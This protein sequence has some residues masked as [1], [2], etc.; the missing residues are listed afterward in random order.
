MDAESIGKLLGSVIS[1]GPV[2]S[3]S[4]AIAEGL[5]LANTL[6]EPNPHK[7]AKA[8]REYYMSMISLVNEVENVK[9]EDLETL[10]RNFIRLM[11]E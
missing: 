4:M 9:Q 1:S 6:S 3:I 10:V 7:R 8:R 5:K 11:D 2:S